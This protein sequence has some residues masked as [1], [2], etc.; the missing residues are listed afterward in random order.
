MSSPQKALTALIILI[1]LLGLGA[2]FFMGDTDTAVSDRF[3]NFAFKNDAVEQEVREEGAVDGVPDDAILTPEEQADFDSRNNGS[4]TE[5]SDEYTYD[6]NTTSGGGASGQSTGGG[7]TVPP[8]GSLWYGYQMD[9][10]SGTYEEED[11]ADVPID[12][13]PFLLLR[14]N[15]VLMEVQFPLE[16]RA[17][18]RVRLG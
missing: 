11:P 14:E 7:S 18:R 10:E 17:I 9:P 3:S 12:T 8:P 6:S 16:Q 13:T 5:T 1:L 15:S 4:N 2:F